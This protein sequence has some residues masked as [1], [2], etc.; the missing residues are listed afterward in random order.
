MK[1]IKALLEK[2]KSDDELMT[3][4]DTLGRTS[5]G[6]EEYITLAAE[7]LKKGESLWISQ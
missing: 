3:K 5:A 4:L 2:A 6:T 7:Y 1:Q